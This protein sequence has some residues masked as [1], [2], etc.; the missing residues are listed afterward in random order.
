MCVCVCVCVHIVHCKPPQMNKGRRWSRVSGAGATPT[1]TAP[2]GST[3]ATT[4]ASV[5]TDAAAVTATTTSRLSQGTPATPAG[6]QRQRRTSVPRLLLPGHSAGHVMDT[7][8]PPPRH[9]AMAMARVSGSY[10][11]R[12]RGSRADDRSGEGGSSSATPRAAMMPH[13]PYTERLQ[14]KSVSMRLAGN[15]G[16]S[17]ALC[18]LLQRTIGRDVCVLMV[19]P[20]CLLCSCRCGGR[21]DT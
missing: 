5:P 1:P 12:A 13:A 18:L 9:S 3:A 11:H 17:F 21:V 6:T 14:A 20:T 7:A 2:K 10:S 16:G 4:A 8:S 15:C 19:L